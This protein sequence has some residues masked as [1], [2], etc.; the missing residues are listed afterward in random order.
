MM[1][2]RPTS[3]PEIQVAALLFLRM[4]CMAVLP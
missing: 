4:P 1:A 3:P 2:E